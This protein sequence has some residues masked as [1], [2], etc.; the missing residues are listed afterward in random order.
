MVTS[1]DSMLVMADFDMYLMKS[2]F[3]YS[4][5]DTQATQYRD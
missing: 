2:D 5:E 3:P 4:L 1:V